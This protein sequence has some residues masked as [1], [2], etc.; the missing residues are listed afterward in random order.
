MT[1]ALRILCT[2]ITPH[3]QLL[4]RAEY[5]LGFELVFEEH[6]FVDAQRIAATEPDRYDVYDQCFHNLDIVWHWGAIQPIEVERIE[7]WSEVSDLTKKGRIGAAASL[8]LGDAPATRLYVQEDRSLSPVETLRI[9][10]LPTVH[11]FDSFGINETE[12]G[13]DADR[14]VR[15]WAELLQP[16]WHGHLAIVD[17][18]AIGFFDIALALRAA[19]RRSF[20]NLG[21]MSVGEIDALIDDA[22][23]LKRSGHLAGLW[24][25][26]EQATAQMAAGRTWIGSIWSPSIIA[27]KASGLKVCQAV[28]VEGYRAW[29][30]GLCLAGHLEGNRLDRAYAYLNW[31]LSGWAGAVAARQGYYMS[32]P[33]RVREHLSPAEWDYWYDGR[34]ARG[35]LCGPDGRPAIQAGEVRS[36]GSYWSRASHIAL[37]NTTMDE[38]NYLV[39]RWSE[40]TGEKAASTRRAS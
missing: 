10:M 38:H 40:L 33:G 37:W 8:G 19:G 27:L 13:V 5:D 14:E 17:E 2:E 1:G 18:P 4:A 7:L 34:P 12:S 16:R 23:E 15:S 22:L 36:G 21:N 28:P 3:R 24:R 32:V 35:V 26:T 6:D 30:G 31:F 29:H 25:T 9:S 20:Q 39:R 11:N